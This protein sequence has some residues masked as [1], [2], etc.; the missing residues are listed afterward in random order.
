MHSSAEKQIPILQV[1]NGLLLAF[2]F[3]LPISIALAEPLAYGVCVLG[4]LMAV[5]SDQPWRVKLHSLYWPMGA[6]FAIAVV[7]V[8][9]SVRPAVSAA[10]IPRL[11]LMGIVPIIATSCAASPEVGLRL[12][13]FFAAGC[14]LRAVFQ[15]GRVL[16]MVWRGGSV[17]DA[18]NMR[19]PQMYLASGLLLLSQISFRKNSRLLVFDISA[20]LLTIL[21]WTLNFK[22]GAWFALALAMAFMI[23][24]SR[25]WRWLVLLVALLGL[26]WSV[27]WT[28]QRIGQMGQEFS[29][30]IGGRYALWTEVAPLMLRRFPQGMGYAATRN[31][32]FAKYAPQVQPNLN[33]LHNNVLQIALE[34]GIAGLLAWAWWVVLVLIVGVRSF[35]T[36]RLRDLTL[37]GL[38]LG[39]IAALGGLL[40]NGMVEFNFG[41][42]EI[43]ML[44]YFLNGLVVYAAHCLASDDIREP[45]A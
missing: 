27:P 40:A 3:A 16:W 30:R 15:A 26:L 2:A 36:A 39:A 19:D 33:H 22:R 20:L 5:R 6:F 34:L 29:A 14:A 8:F 11:L 32:D 21:G 37:A 42:S 17:F 18:G 13:R 43:L 10:K 9:F 12:V 25:R 4:V 41:D 1:L 38:S 28:R 35:L 44:W 45:S 24:L 23:L 7:S 31:T